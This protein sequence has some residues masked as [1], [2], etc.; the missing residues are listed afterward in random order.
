M[1]PQLETITTATLKHAEK[2]D[3]NKKRC[4]IENCSPSKAVGMAHIWDRQTKSSIVEALEWGWGMR[5]GSL[6]LDTSRNI[7]FLGASLHELYKNRKWAL[8]P[9]ESVVRQYLY[10]SFDLPL[11]R[12]DFRDI[13]GETFKYTFQPI[14]DM[15][16]IYVARQSTD[17]PQEVAVHEYPFETF[18][19]LTSHVH[20]KYVILHLGDILCSGLERSAR[21]RILEKY[22]W[23]AL[24]ESLYLRW[25][26]Y[27]PEDADQDPTY[28]PHHPQDDAQ[29]LSSLS[30]STN[31]SFRTPLRRIQPLVGRQSSTSSSSSSSSAS[32]SNSSSSSA[33]SN[34]SQSVIS[35]G[36]V[37]SNASPGH[38]TRDLH[39]RL[40]TC[41]ALRDQA[42]DDG[43]ENPKWTK[44]RIASWAEQCVP[45]SPPP[46]PRRAQTSKSSKRQP[47][48]GRK[49]RT[50]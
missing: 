12:N 44:S 25:V 47:K 17:D 8:V 35:D 24:V 48:K 50:R 14:Q 49:I 23:L 10:K 18:P 45:C 13:Q 29:S 5:K 27:L 19:V 32:S 22:P 43:L 15:E 26:A 3:Y 7:L 31:A 30:I 42:R 1:P 2:C 39:V 33:S 37:S 4:L 11:W 16:D 36:T 34:T 38:K 21:R 40:L 6:N 28:V 20:P 46:A 9:E 41:R